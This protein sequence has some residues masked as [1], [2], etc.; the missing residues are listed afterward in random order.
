MIQPRI[1]HRRT[2]QAAD[3]SVVGADA[4]IGGGEDQS[5]LMF[6][7]ESCNGETQRRR[8][9]DK[10]VLRVQK[11]PVGTQVRGGAASVPPI[12][13]SASSGCAEITR[14]S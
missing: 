1:E 8:I 7:N 2:D 9:G 13:T 11:Q 12:C 10:A 5:R 3:R 6:S 4:R 14:I